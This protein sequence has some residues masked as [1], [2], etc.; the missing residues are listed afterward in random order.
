[1]SAKCI[2]INIKEIVN[3]TYAC[4]KKKEEE[5]GGHAEY[6]TF[7]FTLYRYEKKLTP[8]RLDS[9]FR[10]IECSYFTRAVPSELSVGCSVWA[11]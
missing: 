10:I 3:S 7:P 4:A 5:F 6:V 1:M 2:N 11:L 9:K 8:N